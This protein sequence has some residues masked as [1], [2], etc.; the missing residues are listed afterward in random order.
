MEHKSISLRRKLGLLSLA[1]A[2]GMLLLGQTVLARWLG[3]VG[4]LCYWLVC[5]LLTFVAVVMAL[6]DIRA[7]RRQ[8]QEETRALFEKTLDEVA[9]ERSEPP[10]SQGQLE[11]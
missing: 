7:I 4:F 11:R 6:L 5:F 1:G 10:S 9:P 2:A 3:G 8:C